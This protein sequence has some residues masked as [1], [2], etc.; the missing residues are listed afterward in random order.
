MSSLCQAPIVTNYFDRDD[1]IA[2]LTAD[3]ESLEPML[4]L[5]REQCDID[6]NDKR[7]VIV[8]CKDVKILGKA[9][10]EGLKVDWEKA[11]PHMVKLAEETVKANPTLRAIIFECTELP[12]YSDAVREAMVVEVPAGSGRFRNLP[13]FDSITASNACVASMV[14]NPLFG[15]DGWQEKWDGAQEDYEFGDN[16]SKKEQQ[17]VLAKPKMWWNR[18]SRNK[19]SA[20]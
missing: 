9:L 7:F 17:R 2:N 16:L 15:K 6:L 4:P 10:E 20:D 8:D 18:T 13:V 14:D 1:L 3:A 5:I 11:T 19:K 12:P